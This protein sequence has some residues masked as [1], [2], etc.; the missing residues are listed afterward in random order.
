MT[1]QSKTGVEVKTGFFW[2]AFIFFFCTPRIEIDQAV[3]KKYWGRHFFELSPGEHQ[4]TVYFVYLFKPRCGENS[5]TVTVAPDTVT[6]IRY[7]MPPWIFVKGSL[8]VS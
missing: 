4:V 1:E 2:L 7:F 6:H 8:K 5:I 3:H